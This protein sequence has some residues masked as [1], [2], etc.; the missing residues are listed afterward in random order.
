MSGGRRGTTRGSQSAHFF[1]LRC[2]KRALPFG[3]N[4]SM[5][6]PRKGSFGASSPT[7]A[8]KA[9]TAGTGFEALSAAKASGRRS[10]SPSPLLLTC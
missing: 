6:C 2:K 8:G 4:C 10:L 5:V 1:K 7:E 3:S 9:A